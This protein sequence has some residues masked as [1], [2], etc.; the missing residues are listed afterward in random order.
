MLLTKQGILKFEKQYGRSVS[1][2][3][4]YN[5]QLLHG[6]MKRKAKFSDHKHHNKIQKT[7]EK[8]LW[9]LLHDEG[10]IKIIDSDNLMYRGIS[11]H[12]KRVSRKR[13]G[14]WWLADFDDNYA[15]RDGGK[16]S[17]M[18]IGKPKHD[19]IFI[20]FNKVF[21]CTPPIYRTAFDGSE[22]KHL[23]SHS[24][25][26]KAFEK[27]KKLHFMQELQRLYMLADD[28]VASDEFEIHTG[29]LM[30]DGRRIE[31]ITG[32]CDGNGWVGDRVDEY[33][34]L[35]PEKS[36]KPIKKRYHGDFTGW[37]SYFITG[38]ENSYHTDGDEATDDEYDS[39]EATDD[40]D[41]DDY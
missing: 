36:I 33:W 32:F 34:M 12:P 27:Y 39:D 41:D 8:D 9:N 6:G 18:I 16:L 22:T 13:M 25:P 4:Q 20:H 31:G 2:R 19:L 17:T 35:T 21:T 29:E 30:I 1:L 10:A 14:H 7:M 15:H 23:I 5:R 38:D 37:G 28:N 11:E 40:S 3:R 24:F 26:K